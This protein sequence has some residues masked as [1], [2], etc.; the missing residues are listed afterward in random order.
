MK[1]GSRTGPAAPVSAPPFEVVRHTLE[2]GLGLLLL[3]RPQLPILSITTLLR[4][5][6]IS[7]SREEAG[8]SQLTA[9]LLPRG[10]A[11]RDAVRLAEDVDALGA[12]LGVHSDHDFSSVGIS[13]LSRVGTEAVRI[14]AEVVTSPAFDPEEVERRRNDVLSAIRRKNDDLVYLVRSR[15]QELVFGDHPYRLPLLGYEETVGRITPAEIRGF[16]ERLYRPNNTLIAVA[17]DFRPAEMIEL[18]EDAFGS[19]RPAPTPARE[20]PPVPQPSGPHVERLQKDG[21][22]QATLR[23]GLLGIPRNHP[24]YVVTT[25]M[26]YVLGGSGFGSRLMRSLREE[27]GLTYGVYSSFHTRRE[28]GYFFAGC[29]TGLDT[30]NAALAGMIEEILRMRDHGVTAEEL[31]RARSYYTGSLPLAFQTND[32]LATLVL[33]QELYGLE[34]EFWNEEIRRIGA[35]TTAEVS[36]AAR[37]YLDPSRFTIVALADFT[38]RQLEINL[39]GA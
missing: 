20:L 9:S 36:A 18:L 23:V 11:K 27:R 35:A 24:D 4:A 10:T 14:L 22:S 25:L 3:E 32:Q 28:H 33:E 19:W 8:L 39:P 12:S 15:F 1:L 17:G 2:N 31:E 16:Y 13:C 34:P 5:G 37:T 7:E 6:V 26:N 21:V 29:Q 38:G 30:M